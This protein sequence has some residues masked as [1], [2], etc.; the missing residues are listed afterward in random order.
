LVHVLKADEYIY[1]S[2]ECALNVLGIKSG[3]YEKFATREEAEEKFERALQKGE[4]LV[5]CRRLV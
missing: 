3:R 1:P 5:T 4:V 2:I